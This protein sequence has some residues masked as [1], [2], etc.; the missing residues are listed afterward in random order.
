MSAYTAEFNVYREQ[1]VHM[2]KEL[3]E[4]DAEIARLEI[5]KRVAQAHGWAE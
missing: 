1:L 3:A 2:T 4:K 5:W